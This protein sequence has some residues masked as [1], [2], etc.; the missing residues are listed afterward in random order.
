MPACDG[1][2]EARPGQIIVSMNAGQVVMD[3]NRPVTTIGRS[4]SA[5]LRLDDRSISGLH[6]EIV[7]LPAGYLLVDHGSKNGTTMRDSRVS[8][9]FL[10]N[11]D[12]F[13]VGHATVRFVGP[14]PNEAEV[15]A[16]ANSAASA[17]AIPAE[18]AVPPAPPAPAAA[19]PDPGGAS[20]VAA[21]PGPAVIFVGGPGAAPVA[22][23]LAA[24][25]APAR[26]GKA[27]GSRIGPAIR[28]RRRFVGE[29]GVPWGVFLICLAGVVGATAVTCWHLWKGGALE[30]S[31]ASTEAP[32]GVA[33]VPARP[34]GRGASTPADDAAAARAGSA[35]AARAEGT[36]RPA[37]PGAREG[38][39]TKAP[40]GGATGEVPGSAGKSGSGRT[41]GVGPATGVGSDDPAGA[42]TAAAEETGDP[43]LAIAGRE[44]SGAAEERAPAGASL[45]GRAEQTEAV[46]EEADRRWDYEFLG[47][48]G[49][50]THVCFILDA[51]ASMSLPTQKGTKL[52]RD[53]M[54][55][56]LL[57]AIEDLDPAVSFAVVFFTTEAYPLSAK[58]VAA[59]AANKA[60]ARNWIERFERRGAT[61]LASGLLKGFELVRKVPADER[62][63]NYHVTLFVLSDGRVRD[64]KAILRGAEVLMKEAPVTIHTVSFDERDEVLKDLA[65]VGNGEY[66]VSR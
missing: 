5:T 18:G 55:Q 54:K 33:P 41:P 35:P 31:R 60:E 43:A 13:R 20:P 8:E 34:D 46:E 11:G 38:S 14:N 40:S 16:R 50:G 47:V 27:S 3:L 32:M 9:V 45:P 26:P 53:I 10:R 49:N 22:V 52:K 65:R 1:N 58:F 51:S 2:N 21:G 24:A 42:S 28:R 36:V 39:G 48:P 19:V 7:H 23:Q 30:T 4:R 25:A 12:I 59:T 15:A 6:C 29:G 57:E 62:P 37:L 17:A 63:K 66:H 44:S 56:H 61:N 64:A